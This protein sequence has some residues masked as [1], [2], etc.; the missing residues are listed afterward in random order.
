MAVESRSPQRPDD[1]LV[2]EKDSSF[3][4]REQGKAA[5]DLYTSTRTNSILPA[6]G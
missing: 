1:L 3:G 5:R 2:Q 6:G 4:P